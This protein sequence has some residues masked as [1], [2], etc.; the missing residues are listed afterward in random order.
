LDLFHVLNH[1]QVISYIELRKN[2]IIAVHPDEQ[3]FLENPEKPRENF[4]WPKFY[5][6]IIHKEKQ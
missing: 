6:I 4:G 5:L 1:P 2:T 3:W